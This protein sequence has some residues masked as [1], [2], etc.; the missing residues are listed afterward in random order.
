MKLSIEGRIS[1]IEL[2]ASPQI[3]DAIDELRAVKAAREYK[4]HRWR[5]FNAWVYQNRPDLGHKAYA[6]RRSIPEEPPDPD[7]ECN[8]G[9]ITCDE[10]G[11]CQMPVWDEDIDI[12]LMSPDHRA[13]WLEYVE[14]FFATSDDEIRRAVDI[15]WA[16]RLHTTPG[17]PSL[18][19]K[20]DAALAS[21]S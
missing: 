17:D 2:R 20:I 8:G 12:N 4:S 9:K 15:L 7:L 10:C 19:E 14:L 13:N 16:E 11:G 3:Q 1:K 21:L 18:S 6:A 5:D